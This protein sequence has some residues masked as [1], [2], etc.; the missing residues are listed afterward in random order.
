M[1]DQIQYRRCDDRDVDLLKRLWI[2]CFPN[3]TEDEIDAF[4]D[5]VYSHC[6]A[7]AGFLRDEPVTMLYLLPA[8]ASGSELCVPVW[9]LYAGGTHPAHR[10]CGYYRELM[11]VAR[12]WAMV[13]DACAIYLRPAQ[14]SL[15]RYYASMGYSESIASYTHRTISS[16]QCGRR[17]DLRDYRKR[18]TSALS[19]SVLLWEPI[20]PIAT[21]FVDHGWLAFE[22]DDGT[23]VLT[24]TVSVLEQLPLTDADIRAECGALW[25]PTCDDLT[26]IE[27]LKR[28]MSYSLL[29]GE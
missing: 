11:S 2:L 21:H 18:R 24:D 10:S 17:M 7:F 5:A 16:V 3:D 4:F 12:D 28:A 9:Y 23:A 26:L 6:A 25:M 19:Q 29:F 20:E 13:S 15:F 27:Q 22:N 8:Q 14:P 1:S